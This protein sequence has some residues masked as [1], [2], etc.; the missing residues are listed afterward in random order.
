MIHDWREINALV[1]VPAYPLPNM[2]A[3][4]RDLRQAKYLSS[5]NIMDTFFC[6]ELDEESKKYTAFVTEDGLWEW[7]VCSLGLAS[8]PGEFQYRMN[9]VFQLAIFVNWLKIYIDD[10]LLHQQEWHPHL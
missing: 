9:H 2:Q 7:N 10:L 4:I 5:V 1:K 3:I 6:M 8:L